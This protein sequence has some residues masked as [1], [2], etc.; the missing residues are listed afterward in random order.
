MSDEPVAPGDLLDD[1]DDQE[2]DDDFLYHLFQGGELLQAG[3]IPDARDQLEKAFALKPKNARGQNLLGLVYF[4][5]GMFGRSVQIYRGLVERF[6]GDVTLRVNLAMVYFKAGQL[7]EAEAELQEAL[8]RSPDHEKAH[9]YLGLVLVRKG[10]REQARQHFAKAGVR[11]LERFLASPPEDQARS[12]AQGGPGPGAQPGVAEAAA[13]GF[14]E[15]EE[16]DLPF[17]GIERSA[18]R[19][20]EPALGTNGVESWRAEKHGP[21]GW[22][23]AQPRAASD[24]VFRISSD[25]LLLAQVS[26]RLFCRLD[27]LLWIEGDASF[28]VVNKRFAGEVTRHPFDAGVRAMVVVEGQGTLAF[29]AGPDEYQLVRHD[30]GAGY[31]VEERVHAFSDTTAWE[32]GRLP[33]GSGNDLAIFHLFGAAQLA[34]RCQGKVIRRRLEGSGRFL[35]ATS[36]LVGWTGNLVPRLV[37]AVPPLP[38]G[39]WIELQGAGDIFHLA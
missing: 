15:L 12:P 29:P 19:A 8:Q 26:G 39:W 14:R 18:Q 9:R 34:L 23:D 7:K 3:R 25:G 38:E 24:E 13:Q 31:F 33:V 27:K 28:G 16:K 11:D 20:P 35:L 22:A 1:P 5:L 32:N 10:E 30:Q 17:S 36:K 4:K 6:P 2:V 37:A 21:L